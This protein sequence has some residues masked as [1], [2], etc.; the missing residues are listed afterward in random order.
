MAGQSR[1]AAQAGDGLELGLGGRHA[2]EDALGVLDERTAGV[3]EADALRAAFEERRTG[4]ALEGGD[5]LGDAGLGV[6]KGLGGVLEGAVFG[7][8]SED[9]QALDIEH[10]RSLSHSS[11]ILI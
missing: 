7:D 11:E 6:G 9:P 8:R 4:L 1:P 5:L 2:R 10:K 3:G